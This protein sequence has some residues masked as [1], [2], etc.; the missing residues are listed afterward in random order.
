MFDENTPGLGLVVFP[1]GVR[2]FFHLRF[3]RGYP[4]R[5]T[6]GRF[7]ETSIDQARGK[8]SELN[9]AYSKWRLDGYKGETPFKTKRDPT[10]DEIA[11]QYVEKHVKS[12]ASRPEK[13]AKFANWQLGAYFGPWRKRK[14]GSIRKTDVLD[15]HNAL[16]RNIGN[17]TANRAVQFLRAVFNWSIEAGICQGENPATGI[18]L[19]HEA[20][21]TRFLQPNEL[22]QLFKALRK[23]E[24][25]RSARLREP[26]DVDWREARR[27]F[28]DALGKSFTGR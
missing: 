27:Y 7:P 5:E 26:R 21:R 13:A 1:S 14:V 24:K 23:R 16:A 22:P 10:L 6:I 20:E 8:A 12:R 15:L 19:F 28:V 9:A 25:H 3:V 2:S 11:T 17:H 4:K 18:K